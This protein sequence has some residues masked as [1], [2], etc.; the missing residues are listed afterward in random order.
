MDYQRDYILRLIHM[1]GDLMRRVFELLDDHQR[2][3]LLDEACREHCGMSLEAAES[4]RPESL[5]ALLAPVPRLM[6]AEF[7]A[8]KAEVFS[9]PVGDAEELKYKALRM[10]ASLYE[11]TQLCDLRAEKLASLKRDVFP[12]LTAADLMDCARFFQQ[13]GWYD[14]MEDALFQALPL[15]TDGTAWA[16]DRDGAAVMLREAS[17]V[18]EPALILRGMTGAEL[19]ESA[20]ELESKPNPHER[21]TDE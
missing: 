11:E 15:E 4:L 19:R 5:L 2:L 3:R 8:A 9:L 10:L 18:T 17:K 6:L 16:R 1:L 13:A 12:M 7:L 20:C 14:E 21:A